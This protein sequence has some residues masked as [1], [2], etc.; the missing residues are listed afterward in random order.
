MELVINNLK[1][2]LIHKKE[3]NN[4]FFYIY[5]YIDLFI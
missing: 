2:I 5:I 3:K 4:Y 1:N